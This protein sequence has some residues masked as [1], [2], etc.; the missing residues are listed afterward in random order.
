M[1]KTWAKYK[2]LRIQEIVDTYILVRKGLINKEIFYIPQNE[3]ESYD[4]DIL[5]F[6]LSE[7]DVKSII[8][9]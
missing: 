8:L 1:M 6:R 4:G 9:C 2:K 7:E 3:V 5:R